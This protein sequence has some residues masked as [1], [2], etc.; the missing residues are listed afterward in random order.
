MMIKDSTYNV[1]NTNARI[2]TCTSIIVPTRR[3]ISSNTDKGILG[4]LI[5]TTAFI[6]GFI[7]VLLTRR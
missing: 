5:V 3:H 2:D 1:Y 6:I 4:D 7:V